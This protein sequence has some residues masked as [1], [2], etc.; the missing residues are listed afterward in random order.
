MIYVI[1]LLSVHQSLDRET[2]SLYS[3]NISASDHG[4]PPRVTFTTLSILIEDLNDNPPRF[5]KSTYTGHVTEND[6]STP[7][8]LSVSA[9]DADEGMFIIFILKN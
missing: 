2:K 9:T 8:I 4:I 1:G 5:D 7:Y 3:L 6:F